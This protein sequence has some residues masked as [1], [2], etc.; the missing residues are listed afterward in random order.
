[1]KDRLLLTS[2]LF[3]LVQIPAQAQ[4]SLDVAKITFSFSQFSENRGGECMR[5]LA[6]VFCAL[7]MPL[8]RFVSSDCQFRGSL[9]DEPV[10][11]SCR[12]ST[13]IHS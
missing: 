9:R 8:V 12:A 1:M 5:C 3:V 2:T 4:V 6:A 11:W 10:F 7:A 13:P